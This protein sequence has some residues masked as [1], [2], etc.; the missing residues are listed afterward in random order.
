M[1]QFEINW[2]EQFSQFKRLI[3]GFSGGLD[4]TV[5]LHNLAQQPALHGRLLAM[6][7][8]HGISVNA[9]NWQYQCQHFCEEL[10]IP[11]LVKKVEFGRQ[12]NLEEEARKARYQ[13][14]S[15]EL[16]PGDGLILAHHLDDQAETLLLQLFRGAGVDGLAAMVAS[17]GF[18]KG[19]LLRPLLNY[20]RQN[21]EDYAKF[22]HLKWLD[23]ES[24][25]NTDF[26]RNFLRQQIF[27]LLRT[28]WPKIANNLTRTTQHC[29]QAQA[30]LEDLA[31]MD[32]PVLNKP[33]S[34][35]ALNSL[36]HLS[37]AR[38]VNV[39]RFWFK[40]NNIKSPSTLIYNQSD[41][42]FDPDKT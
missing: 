30:N 7:I 19:K 22:H 25:Q 41:P 27:P 10:S 9:E 20:S 39:L 4:S 12:A 14:F 26:S 21:L 33:T 23:D 31:K 18:A 38:M 40:S 36:S 28:R 29:Q 37:D 17:K 35:L 16:A 6:H 34:T 1:N 24:N 13:A 5:L 11:F 15:A 42:G 32:C 2:I 8:N 3:V